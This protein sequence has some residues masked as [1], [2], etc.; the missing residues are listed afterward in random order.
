MIRYVKKHDAEFRAYGTIVSVDHLGVWKKLLIGSAAEPADLAVKE[1][2]YS[3]YF[4][5]ELS[6]QDLDALRILK[7]EVPPLTADLETVERFVS[8]GEG[9][10][11]NVTP[12]SGYGACLTN[13]F[14]EIGR[15]HV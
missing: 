4:E 7:K 9:R 1:D 2:F 13:G 3:F 5:R 11:I 10:G 6:Y 8:I 12:A 14:H 15:A